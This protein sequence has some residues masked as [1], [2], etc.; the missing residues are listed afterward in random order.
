MSRLEVRNLAVSYGRVRAVRGISLSVESP[1]IVALVG[2][3]GAGKST[4][5]KSIIGLIPSAAGEISFAGKRIDRLSPPQIVRA[6]IAI[7]PEGRRLFSD[8]PVC[9]NLRI[10]AYQSRASNAALD[11]IYEWFPILSE[12]RM[13][14]AGNLS[15][16]QQQM[17]AIGRALMA[18]PRLL[19][20]D[21]PSL[22]LA[23]MMVREVARIILAIHA[24]GISVLLAE[25]NARMALKLCHRAYVL[26]TG[27]VT[28]T[29]TGTEMLNSPDVQRSYLGL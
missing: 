10:G 11:E 14:L 5:L 16:G 13:Q 26:Q 25:Q 1:E 20:L 27:H 4:L 23:P 12:R 15:G 19:L 29:G 9:E 21:E 8:M 18:K 22:G 24:R 28:L 17:V 7:S 3:N 6:G 2:S